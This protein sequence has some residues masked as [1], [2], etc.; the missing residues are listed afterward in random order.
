MWIVDPKGNC[1]AGSCPARRSLH[2]DA[3]AWQLLALNATWVLILTV[4][5]RVVNAHAQTNLAI[6]ATS[7][8]VVS[9]GYFAIV[10]QIHASSTWAHRVAYCVGGALGGVLGV[11]VTHGIR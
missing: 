10:K 4:N 3:K 9:A 7:Q 11:V 1:R 6:I 8:I 5:S 2:L